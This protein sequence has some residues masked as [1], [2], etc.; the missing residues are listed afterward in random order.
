MFGPVAVLYLLADAA[1]RRGRLDWAQLV[2][3][4]I[5]LVV[6]TGPRLVRARIEAGEPGSR[7]VGLLGTAFGIALAS[8]VGM[9]VPSIAA[10]SMGA[11]AAATIGGI[12]VDL[13]CSVPDAPRGLR[14]LRPMFGATT[15]VASAAGLA[16]ALAP[17]WI[18]WLAPGTRSVLAFAPWAYSAFVFALAVLFRALRERLGSTPSALAANAWALLGLI[19][20]FAIGLAVLVTIA[21][22]LHPAAFRGDWVGL[23]LVA[24]AS[25]YGHVA[26]VESS[27]RIE[28]A[29]VV[30]SALEWTFAALVVATAAAFLA[31]FIARDRIAWAL[32]AM[33]LLAMAT[34]L[35]RLARPV[36][37]RLFAPYAGKL[38]DAIDE[39]TRAVM[40]STTLED[41]AAAALGPFRRASGDADSDPR[42]I[43]TDPELAFHLDAAGI[44]H[45]R[46]ESASE[47]LVK[48]F[49]EGR[50]SILTFVELDANVVRRPEL[51]PLHEHLESLSALA[52]V[53]VVCEGQLEAIVVVPSGRRA[54]PPSLEELVGLERYA[55]AIA[56]RISLLAAHQRSEG[57]VGRLAFDRDRAEER[58]ESLDDE[59]RRLRTEV[60]VLR[61]ER[62]SIGRGTTVVAYS[63]AGRDLERAISDVAPTPS[64]VTLV[65]E[66]GMYVDRVAMRIHAASGVAEGPFVL[67]DCAALLD[68]D[69]ASSFFGVEGDAGSPGFLRLADG[70][71][72]LLADVAALPLPTQKALAEALASRGA[73]AVGSHAIYGFDV[74]IVAVCR[75]PVDALVERGALDAELARRLGQ[76]QIRVPPLRERI[77][78]I[79]SLALLAVDRASRRLGRPAMG[80]DQEALERLLA[81]PWPGNV[82][83]LELVVELA[84]ESTE[85]EMV[86]GATVSR[87]LSSGSVDSIPPA[88]LEGSLVDIERRALVR[89]LEQASGNKS[90]AARAL[91]LKRTTFLDKLRRFGLDEGQGTPGATP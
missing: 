59:V 76:T 74:R 12:I 89:A 73:R 84:A 82:R 26:L 47:L 86:T 1:S 75:L 39:S 31:G 55:N 24:L 28:A 52:V 44:A 77:D 15:A 25:L 41:F 7:R 68:D 87:M 36:V 42:F 51:R 40:D 5:A 38:L 88:Q 81:Y 11:V 33:F 54:S 19:P 70:G 71:T 35:R 65:S 49:A 78:D 18:R 21:F 29:S 66:P 85:S 69:A 16:S 90:E 48:H 17:I 37:R 79:P 22:G 10:A 57:R 46:K 61:Q 6:S 32:F 63:A 60:R 91:G 30:R 3:G 13:A 14:A 50:S 23:V 72:L 45:G 64:A 56:P 83:E 2:V 4:A 27:R 62:G 8:R 43:V 9:G 80:I 53:P 67:A 20:S 58:A 34:I